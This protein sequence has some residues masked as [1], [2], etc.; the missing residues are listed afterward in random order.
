MI[1][2]EIVNGTMILNEDGIIIENTWFDLPNHNSNYNNAKSC[3]R[4]RNRR[5]GR[6]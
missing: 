4:N 3:P 6:F 2:G 5:R 1:F